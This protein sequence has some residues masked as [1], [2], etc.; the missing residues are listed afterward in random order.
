MILLKMCSKWKDSKRL[1]LEIML[2]RVA[3]IKLCYKDYILLLNNQ[4]ELNKNQ[5]TNHNNKLKLLNNYK[6]II[7]NTSIK[8]KLKRRKVSAMVMILQL[9]KNGILLVI[10]LRR[11]NYPNKLLD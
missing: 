9:I 6:R 10:N 1:L 11:K 7:L 5:D 3:S 2:F 8:N 4:K